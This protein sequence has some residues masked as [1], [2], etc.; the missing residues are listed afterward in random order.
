MRRRGFHVDAIYAAL[1]ET[2]AA[3]CN[4]PLDDADIH[5]IAHSIGRYEPS[6]PVG[7]ETDPAPIACIDWAALEPQTPPDREWI[8][9]HWYGM[10]HVTLLA[11]AGGS[12]KTSV[13]Q[14][15]A[16]CLALGR[17]YL[18]AVSKPRNVLLW[19]A[20]DDVDELWRRQLAIA[21]WLG[22]ALSEF[23]QRLFVHS[24]EGEDCTLAA[25]LAEGR[26]STTTRY[27][28]LCQQIGDYR[29]EAVILDNSARLYGGSENDRH[30]VTSF[31]QLL[32][33]AARPTRAGL[34]LLAHPG[35]AA[36]SEYSGSTAW[37]GAVRSRLYLGR[38]LPD[39]VGE[40]DET[41]DESARYICR[42]KAN[43]SAMDWRRLTYQNGVM[44]PEEPEGPRNGTTP[45]YAVGVV[46]RAIRKLSSM[47]EYGTAS[48]ASPNYLPKLAKQYGLLEHVT[49]KEFTASMR[50]MRKEGKLVLKA[51]GKYANRTVKEALALL[52]E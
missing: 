12:G 1:A 34:L 11:G 14:V 36:G 44:V 19:A 23:K 30:Q 5:R 26:L 21:Q 52:E 51:I 9:D 13:A 24:Y 35:K 25:E 6:E 15:M 41:A 49:D 16:S 3:R 39:D 2:N 31:V 27:G 46:E 10:G 17:P 32:T 42:R 48:T 29:A 7:A 45:M 8:I 50:A 4:P 28:E 43:Y 18:D 33:R 22:V 38:K 47:G 37:E 20:E 40:P